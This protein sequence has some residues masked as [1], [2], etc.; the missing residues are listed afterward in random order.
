MAFILNLKANVKLKLNSIS[1]KARKQKSP[2]CG[3][4]TGLL[5]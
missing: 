4:Q 5:I 1:G 2:D 3:I